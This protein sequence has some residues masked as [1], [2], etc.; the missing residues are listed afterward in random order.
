[1]AELVAK[2]EEYL[3][4][5][6]SI[7]WIHSMLIPSYTFEQ[8]KATLQENTSISESVSFAHSNGLQFHQ[9]RSNVVILYNTFRAVCIER[10]VMRMSR[11]ELHSKNESISYFVAKDCT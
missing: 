9:T 8:F 7:V 1:M 10:V 3:K 6:F 4:R 11:E 2:K 5:D